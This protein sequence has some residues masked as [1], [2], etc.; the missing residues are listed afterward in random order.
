V[1]VKACL[2]ILLQSPSHVRAKRS[3]PLALYAAQH[4]VDHAQ[5][6]MVSK[7]VEDGMQHLF[8]LAKPHFTVWLKL[9]D[10]DKSW[11]DFES[12]DTHFLH[13]IPPHGSP[14]YYASL[15]GFHDL[16]AHL[17]N[18]HPHHVNARVGQ[19]H[20]PLVAA[21]RNN[22]FHTAKLLHQHGA[23]LGIRSNSNR[24]VLHAASVKGIVNIAQWLLAHGEDP[25][26]RDDNHETPLH[27]AAKHGWF[28]FVRMLLRHGII[29]NAKNK[30][31]RTPLHLA[32]EGGHVECVWLLL[33]HRADVATQDSRD[34][35][36]LH[37]AS[38]WVSAKC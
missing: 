33:W 7:S 20:S 3:S 13:G 15:C 37:L 8:D 6:E 4:W 26:L 29:V 21:F 32:S 28:E 35:T 5:F 12:S 24:T 17:I 34:S 1:I 23:N 19:N 31:N 10:I 9:Y 22:H 2:G 38:S 14:L 27:L 36:P 18:E 11:D 25:N 30:D 16:T